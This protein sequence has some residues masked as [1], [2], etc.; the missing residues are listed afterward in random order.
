M[1][2]NRKTVWGGLGCF[3]GPVSLLVFLVS[4]DCCVA[5]PHDATDLSIVV[6]PNHTHLYSQNRKYT[7]ARSLLGSMVR[8]LDFS[9]RYVLYPV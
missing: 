1:S 5:D 4:R 7:A 3:H 8:I 9:V 2:V 6:F